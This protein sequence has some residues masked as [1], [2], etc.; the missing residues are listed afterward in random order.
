MFCLLRF[1]F[2]IGEAFLI[3]VGSLQSLIGLH[4]E[5]GHV[6]TS[7]SHKLPR[8]ETLRLSKRLKNSF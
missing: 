2:T 3:A 5:N 4:P 7:I 6:K 1:T 8:A